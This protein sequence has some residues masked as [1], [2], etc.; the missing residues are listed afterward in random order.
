MSLSYLEAKTTP[1]VRPAPRGLP[2][3]LPMLKSL[4]A[5]LVAAYGEVRSS[6][7]C[8]PVL[9]RVSTALIVAFSLVHLAKALIT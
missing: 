4:R 7:Q 5:E 3:P 1:R 6:R 2:K 9:L 8:R